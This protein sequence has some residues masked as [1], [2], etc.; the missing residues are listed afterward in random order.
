MLSSGLG[1]IGT[2]ARTTIIGGGFASR[3]F[4]IPAGATD[5]ILT[6]LTIDEGFANN[7][8]GG[9]ILNEGELV[10]LHVAVTGGF[11]PE[12]RGRRDRQLRRGPARRRRA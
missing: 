3:V 8:N 10:L 4:R 11:A 1:I 12:R 5:V 9:N 2:S 6:R 7:A